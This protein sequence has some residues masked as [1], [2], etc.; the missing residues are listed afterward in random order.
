MAA[1]LLVFKDRLIKLTIRYASRLN[2]LYI[3]VFTMGQL[4]GVSYRALGCPPF[5]WP[6]QR[7]LSKRSTVAYQA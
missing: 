7:V 6:A 2:A 5:D 1:R 4:G 3:W